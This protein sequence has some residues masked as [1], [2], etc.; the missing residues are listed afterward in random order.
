M[1]C[2]ENLIYFLYV[3]DNDKTTIEKIIYFNTAER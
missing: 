1:Y 3:P 2:N